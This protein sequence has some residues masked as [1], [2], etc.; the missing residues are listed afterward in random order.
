VPALHISGNWDGDGIGTF[1]NWD[2]LRKLGRT[3]QWIIFGPWIHAFNT[4]HSLGDVEYG[5]DAIIEMDSIYLRWF[6]TWLKGKSVGLNSMPHVKLFV[7][8]A[9]KWIEAPQ[10]PSAA[11]PARMLYL[12][13][14]SLADTPGPVRRIQY[15]YDPKLDT[16]I[17]ARMKNGNIGE[18]D[19]NLP[20][21]ELGPSTLVFKGPPLKRAM[22][23]TGPFTIKLHFESSAQNTDL[24]CTVI[25]IDPKG[26][27][28]VLG[29]AGKLRA[30]YL[31]GTNK[32]RALTPGKEYVAT[33][34]PWE[35]AHEFAPGH[36][37][38]LVVLSSMF[39]VFARNLG[40]MDPIATATRMVTQHNTLL[41]G[42]GHESSFTFHVLWK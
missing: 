30:S 31:H 39:P 14:S 29:I 6:D 22:A 26:H 18:G 12:N 10:W 36:R 33:V 41:V 17:P 24:Y 1:L 42:R 37:I 9:N 25:D 2:A 7:T 19:T 3:D 15:T 38:G 5:P 34:V 11:M 4:T 40:T 28:R 27:R 35:F 16:K 20:D 23:I 13:P 32:P 8:G 21:S